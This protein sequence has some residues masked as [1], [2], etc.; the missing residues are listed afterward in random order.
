MKKKIHDRGFLKAISAITLV[1]GMAGLPCT[2]RAAS[3]E[4]AP[5]F[6]TW[7]SE[8]Q[9]EA[10]SRGFDAAIVS[11]A[12]AG[13][14]PIERVIELDRRQPEF[15]LTFR[16]YLDGAISEKRVK[17]GRELLVEHKVLLDQVATKYGV[18]PRFLIAFWGLETNF[19]GYFGAFPVAG[20]L[21]TLAHDRRRAKFFR[22]QLLAALDIMSR[23]DM[24]I[25]VKGSWAGAMGNFQF[26]PTT[27]R[28]FAIDFD[29]DGKRDLWN[30]MKDGFGS[31][32]NY[33]SRSG[34]D[35]NGTW[36]R[37]IRLP[38]GFD[39]ALAGLDR[40]RTL[41][42]WQALGVRRAD[43]RDLPEADIEGAIVIPSGHKGPSFM[44]Y[45]NFHTIL[46]WN[47]SIFYAI[48]IGH[49]ADRIIGQGGLLTPP[50]VSDVPM[51]RADV[52]EMQTRLTSS[53]FDTGGSDGVIGRMTRDAIRSFQKSVGL[54]PDAY[55]S[56]DI[57]KR[58]RGSVEN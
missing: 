20:S 27:Y 24:P 51:S 47:R 2:S 57:L 48:A 44:V 17:R 46:K 32:A 21:V 6:D 14:S 9:A 36:G 22:E 23:G 13:V 28:D 1:I 29:G 8:L 40:N 31:A 16:K 10:V 5:P 33:L 12:L 30:N 15:T 42:E 37:E 35:R 58:L 54:P 39:F 41:A 7:L 52:K 50:P 11:S 53:G 45:T 56:M 19:G 25:D 3:E 4:T 34:W 18:Q 49:L 43:G 26:I 55:P 38:D